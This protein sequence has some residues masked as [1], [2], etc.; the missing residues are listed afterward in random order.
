MAITLLY[1]DGLES[2]EMEAPNLKT[3]VLD[4]P[5]VTDK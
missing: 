3:L 5:I 1:D 2:F 4:S